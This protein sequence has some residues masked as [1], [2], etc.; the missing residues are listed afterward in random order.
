MGRPLFAGI[1]EKG[2]KLLPAHEPLRSQ[3]LSF[4]EG[5]LAV[6]FIQ[7]STGFILTGYALWL[8]AG[9]AALS[10]LGALP[11]LGQLA[12]PLAL[13]FRGSRKKLT[14]ALAL[15]GRI[16]FGLAL[17]LPLLPSEWWIPA[18]VAVAAL[19]QIIMGPLPVVWTSWMADL[20]PEGIRGRYFGLRNGVLGL[21][22]TVGSLLAGRVVDSLIKPWGFLLVLGVGV[23]L[24]VT[25]ARILRYQHEPPHLTNDSP[26]ESLLVP[27]RDPRFRWFLGFVLAWHLAL[28]VGS[29]LVGPMFLEYVGMN[30]TQL[31]IWGVI[32]AVG[33]LLFGPLWGRVADRVGHTQVLIWTCILAGGPLPLMWLLGSPANL[34]VIWLSAVM[35]AIAWSGVN[36]AITN[37]T[38][39]HAPQQERSAYLAWFW[40]ATA[41]GGLVGAAVGGAVGSLNLIG[42]STYHLPVFVSMVL[43]VG[44]ALF[45]ARLARTGRL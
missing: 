39:H 12:A 40:I 18:L 29:P 21:I 44:S 15:W 3:T 43:R 42:P 31:G 13:F 4:Y 9:P 14:I 26:R 24:G 30:F 28:M 16:V 17:L 20:V 36:A 35:D 1:I 45:L 22:A 25:A 38:L 5:A 11:F 19:S 7:W 33:G 37:V 8:G 34:E 27:I 10:A 2:M 6:L 41:V 32:S 23:V